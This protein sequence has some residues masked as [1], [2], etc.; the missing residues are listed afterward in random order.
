M[1]FDPYVDD[2]ATRLT[3]YETDELPFAPETVDLQPDQLA[4][5][6]SEFTTTDEGG[7]HSIEVWVGQGTPTGEVIHRVHYHGEHNRMDFMRWNFGYLRRASQ[8]TNPIGEGEVTIERLPALTLAEEYVA[9][10]GWSID[11]VVTDG[12]RVRVDPE[13]F[14]DVTGLPTPDDVTAMSDVFDDAQEDTNG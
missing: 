7:T 14:D 3:Y 2:L 4:V 12:Y 13:R 1:S 6:Y 10:Y 8:H 11:P 5:L 9:H